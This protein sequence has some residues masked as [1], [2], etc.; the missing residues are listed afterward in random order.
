MRDRDNEIVDTC[1]TLNYPRLVNG[2]ETLPHEF[3]G[4]VS[5]CSTTINGFKNGVYCGPD[6]ILTC[7][8]SSFVQLRLGGYAVMSHRPKLIKVLNGSIQ[9]CEAHGIYINLEDSLRRSFKDEDA[10]HAM[11]KNDRAAAA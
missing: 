5:L 11:A 7:E 10:A 8:S 6:A 4:L 9:K 2:V 1:F 3:C